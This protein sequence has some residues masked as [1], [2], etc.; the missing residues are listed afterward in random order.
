MTP[1]NSDVVPGNNKSFIDL[2]AFQTGHKPQTHAQAYA[3]EHR[4]PSRL[5][6]ELIDRYVQISEH[7][8]K[9]M[10]VDEGQF[11]IS[12]IDVTFCQKTKK[13]KV[14]FWLETDFIEEEKAGSIGVQSR[15]EK[16]DKEDEDED[17][18]ESQEED[19]DEEEQDNTRTRY[20]RRRLH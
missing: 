20:K 3:L 10:C 4:F 6:P 7:W 14:P 17:R 8:H 15:F 2:L 16:D 5:Q 9:Y 12:T 18:E 11:N 13:F 1:F 19:K